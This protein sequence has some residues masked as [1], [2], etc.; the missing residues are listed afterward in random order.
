MSAK[1]YHGGVGDLWVG[2]VI[3]PNMGHLRHV[4]GCSQCE[5]Q[6]AGVFVDGFDPPTPP[7]W[8][9]A[10]TDREYARYH[11]SRAYKGSLYVVDLEGDV[12]KS[13]ED[14]FPSWRGRRA[15]VRGVLERNITLTMK[16]RKKLFC[17][18]G[19]TGA[20]FDRMMRKTLDAPRVLR[21][22]S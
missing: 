22:N 10:T 4:E 7:N 13:V 8:V 17:R 3:E 6:A 16:Q 12:E 11:A 14:P 18:W 1:L 19:G 9:Y 2:D 21:Q 15:T 5:A 20:E